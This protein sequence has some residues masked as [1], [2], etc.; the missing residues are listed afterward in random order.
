M[1]WM[2]VCQVLLTECE[3][4]FL[5]YLTRVGSCFSLAVPREGMHQKQRMGFKATIL[6]LRGQ[7]LANPLV[8][9]GICLMLYREMGCKAI[10]KKIICQSCFK[11]AVRCLQIPPQS[12]CF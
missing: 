8:L 2:E 12:D 11:H 10:F 5:N 9:S 7:L 3:E 1:R 4:E 6:L